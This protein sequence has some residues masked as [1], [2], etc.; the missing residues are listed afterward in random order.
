MAKSNAE[1][2]RAVERLAQVG[3]DL[4]E[5]PD[6]AMT[7]M[8]ASEGLGV[9]GT[10]FA[11]ASTAGDLV[12]KLDEQRVDELG[13]DHMVMRGRPMREWAV[14]PFDQGEERWRSIVGEAYAFVDAIAP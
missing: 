10:L 3:S 9:R 1:R 4:L 13:L 11:F 5:R 7:H 14:V 2:E 12:V 8:F 6:V